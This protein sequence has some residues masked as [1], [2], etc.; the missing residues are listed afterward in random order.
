M[1]SGG[2]DGEPH[3]VE[4]FRPGYRLKGSVVRPASVRIE[5]R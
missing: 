5:R 2:S 1:Q 4:V 3:V